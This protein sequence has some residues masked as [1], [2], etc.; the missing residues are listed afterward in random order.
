MR[1][2]NQRE[3]IMPISVV[4][5]DYEED[6]KE[7]LMQSTPINIPNIQKLNYLGAKDMLCKQ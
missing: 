5:Q 2:A 6:S 7:V 4:I 1:K 3:L